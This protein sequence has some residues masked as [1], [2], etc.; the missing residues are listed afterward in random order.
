M[1]HEDQTALLYA[2]EERAP[3]RYIEV[4]NLLLE[5]PG[6][7]VNKE[8]EHGNNALHFAAVGGH[9]EAVQKLLDFHGMDVNAR[10][11]KGRTPE[12]YARWGGQD[13]VADLLKKRSG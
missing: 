7:D 12:A 9:V 10:G 6:I 13:E 3:P 2:L 1:E 5:A 11:Y 8:T 4:V